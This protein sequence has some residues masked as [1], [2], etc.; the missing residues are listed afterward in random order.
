MSTSTPPEIPGLVYVQP[1]G[2]GGY[3]DVFLYEQQMPRMNVAVKV[4]KGEGLT[5]A[6]RRQ[7]ADEADTM[8]QLAD[9]PYIVQVFRAE[10]SADGRP[11][12]VM[13]YY[14]PPNMAMRARTERFTVEEVLRIGIQLASA[15][16]TAHRAGITHRDIKPANVLVSQYGAPGLTDFGIAG[17]GGAAGEEE[18]DDVGVSVPWAPPEVLFGQS[19]GDE[20]ADVYSL[21]ATLWQLLVGRSPFEVGGGDNSAYALMPRIRSNPVPST[22]RADVPVSL[23][24]LLAQSMA[25]DPGNRPATAL[26]FA[27]ALQEIEQEQRFPRTAIV[28]LDDQGQTTL[29]D[30]T[31]APG[32]DEDDRTRV[33]SPQAVRSAQAL[34]QARPDRTAYPPLSGS[35]SIP[36][37]AHTSVTSPRPGAAPPGVPDDVAEEGTVRVD[38]SRAAA[39][40]AAPG[41]LGGTGTAPGRTD[42]D[43]T[44]RH[45]ISPAMLLTGVTVVVAVLAAIALWA[46]FGRGDADPVATPTKTIASQTDDDPVAIAPVPTISARGTTGGVAFSWTYPG[47]EKG[48][49][50]RFRSAPTLEGLDTATFVNAKSTTRVVKVAKGTQVCGQARVIRSGSESNWSAPQCEKAG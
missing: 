23:D 36:A 2:S 37:A 25:K 21:A 16:E 41:Q 11:Y 47:A 17:R 32:G 20:R 39:G 15:V 13:K 12:L 40:A 46:V 6:I 27:R 42:P 26:A 9:H 8:A 19:N 48:D 22:G 45:E 30:Q 43:D 1:V 7:F 44:E 18:A 3:A 29:A 33:R 24:R 50:Y 31:P 38:R 49:A 10:T 4:L 14:P 34:P 28:V 5:P 35:T